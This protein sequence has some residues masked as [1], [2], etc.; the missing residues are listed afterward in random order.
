VTLTA[1][2]PQSVSGIEYRL[3][4]R[5]AWR[6]YT[7]PVTLVRGQTLTWRAV[8]VNGNIEASHS[9]TG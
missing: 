5:H 6:R 1:T 8:D 2:D 7:R 4:P 9:L 3:K